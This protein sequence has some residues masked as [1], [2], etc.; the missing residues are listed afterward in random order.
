M[1]PMGRKFYKNKKGGKH[2]VKIKGKFM[3]WWEDVCQPSK[4]K[5]KREAKKQI[6]LDK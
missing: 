4:T 1:K 2:H 3:A 6:E 5:E